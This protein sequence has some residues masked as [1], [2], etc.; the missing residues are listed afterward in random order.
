MTCLVT[1]RRRL[2]GAGAGAD[3]WRRCLIAQARFACDARIDLVQVRERD[4]DGA[5][6]A[7][8]VR[9]IAAVARGSSTR[10]IVNDRLDVALA[11]GA[12]GVHLRSDSVA[13]VDARRMA[14]PG[15]LIG[16]SVHAIDD[17]TSAQGVDYLVAGTVFPT[18]S[19]RDSAPLLGVEG[20]RAIVR[21][22][23]VA[24]LAIGGVTESRVEAVA[25]AGAAGCA[26]IGLFMSDERAPG[27]GD[28]GAIP[29][30]M[31]VERLRRR[32]DSVKAA[33]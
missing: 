22:S 24:V 16:R 14:P 1:D 9:A 13:A 2:A 28:C 27:G 32:F 15:F 10:V 17:V 33:S 20:L 25:R 3:A 11:A 12:D 5:E 19:K 6:L 21:A 31:L 23:R 26:A 18:S 29:L 4:L 8:A 30:E 7:A